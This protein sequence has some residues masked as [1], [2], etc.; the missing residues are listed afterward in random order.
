MFRSSI[1]KSKVFSKE[2]SDLTILLARIS[3]AIYLIAVTCL[4]SYG[5]YYLLRANEDTLNISLFD[6][7]AS[8]LGFST[9][10]SLDRTFTATKILA[11]I[12]SKHCPEREQWP[13]CSAVSVD[14]YLDYVDTLVEMNE[15]LRGIGTN[16]ILSDD[17]VA[18]FEEF[19]YDY[20][21]QEGHGP[22]STLPFGQQPFGEG[23]SARDGNGSLFHSNVSY[24]EGKR[25]ILVPVFLNGKIEANLKSLMFNVY[26]EP[27]RVR[28]VDDMLDC[29]NITMESSGTSQADKVNCGSI[30]DVIRLVQDSFSVVRPA[31]L[32]FFPI[33][34]ANDFTESGAVALTSAIFNWDVV[35]EGHL[36]TDTGTML[37][38]LTSLFATFSFEVMGDSVTILG[39]GDLHDRS[40][41]RYVHRF[42]LTSSNYSDVS[43]HIS[44]YPTS[45]GLATTN[46]PLYGCL[47]A[48][49][50]IML[51]SLVVGIFDGIVSNDARE[52]ELV[53]ETKRLF[54]R[55][56]S[57]EIRT[58][59]NTVHLGL[60]YLRTDIERVTRQLQDQLSEES[61]SEIDA[62]VNI[63][64]E[65]EE[66][67]DI[68]VTVLNDLINYDKIVMGSLNL[69]LGLVK[70]LDSV[71][72]TCRPFNVQ[73]KQKDIALRFEVHDIETLSS[74]ICVAD[75]VKIEQVIRNLV[76][77]SL[78]FTPSKGCVTVAGK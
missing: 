72:F 59:L 64:E 60:V 74:L 50:V 51:T 24:M 21:E 16:V 40:L 77:N 67:A 37:V 41:D 43:Y 14:F 11:S 53:G 2:H 70:I 4:F 54:V 29:V 17:Q 46:F 61:K 28:G 31:A 7:A 71:Q 38:V 76:G 36:A 66:S 47:V 19:A 62:W 9:Q 22:N 57:H 18:G 58:P 23:I 42:T 20:Y 5:S 6:S 55:Y 49:L 63:V 3:V 39:E 25:R 48:V 10:S 78:K 35:F 56:I 33:F 44:V 45:E 32:I 52:R 65:I 1:S 12:M 15:Q 34:P 30:T 75:V 26:N 8:D 69:E 68:A 73:A 13:N 27:V